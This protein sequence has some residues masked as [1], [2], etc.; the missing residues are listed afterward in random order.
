MKIIIEVIR[1]H[2][3][4]TLRLPTSAAV[5]DGAPRSVYL[6]WEQRQNAVHYLGDLRHVASIVWNVDVAD[7]ELV[8]R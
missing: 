2:D 7:I 3:G 8:D 6:S 1:K 5:P 4:I